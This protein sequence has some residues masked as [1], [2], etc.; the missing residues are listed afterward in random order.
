MPKIGAFSNNTEVERAAEIMK[1]EKR[2]A[3]YANANYTFYAL[4]ADRSRLS[5]DVKFIKAVEDL[6]DGHL[7]FPRFF[8][9]F[10]THFANAVSYGQRSRF[11]TLIS[12]TGMREEVSKQWETKSEA[13]G[14]IKAVAI[15]VSGSYKQAGS[16]AIE[17][18]R[19]FRET[20]SVVQGATLSNSSDEI[21]LG[22]NQEVVVPVAFDLRPI[23]QV[24]SP[25][26]F[27]DPEIFG[28][29]RSE[30]QLELFDYAM[31]S[32]DEE[33]WNDEQL[34]PQVRR[35]KLEKLVPKGVNGRKI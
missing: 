22:D 20:I 17:S 23:W 2:T 29:L 7:T 4:V 33:L 27:D 19:K 14:V 8:E 28:R 31:A 12:E 5:L 32:V 11:Q 25:L 1:S 34:L 15:G 18:E 9:D 35:I 6:R 21:T 24:L 30:M 16:Q 13:E 3:I 10:G 26:Y